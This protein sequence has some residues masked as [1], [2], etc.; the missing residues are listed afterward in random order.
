[1]SEIKKFDIDAP[2]EQQGYRYLGVFPRS[3]SSLPP[4]EQPEQQGYRYLGVF[5][6]SSSFLPPPPGKRRMRSPIAESSE[7]EGDPFAN[8]PFVF[9]EPTEDTKEIVEVIDTVV[10]TLTENLGNE[11]TSQII[12]TTPQA[13]KTL[14]QSDD[15][16]EKKEGL[17]RFAAY[18][19][20]MKD[21]KKK[22]LSNPISTGL[23]WFVWLWIMLQSGFIITAY[24]KEKDNQDPQYTRQISKGLYLF[25]VVS[26]TTGWVAFILRLLRHVPMSKEVKVALKKTEVGE[27]DVGEGETGETGETG[28]VDIPK[29]FHYETGETGEVVGMTGRTGETGGTETGGKKSLRSRAASG[30]RSGASRAKSA[31]AG[32][33]KGAAQFFKGIKAMD[34]SR[35]NVVK[36]SKRMSNVY[37]LILWNFVLGCWAVNDT[38]KSPNP[39]PNKTVLG[40][41]AAAIVVGVLALLVGILGAWLKKI[42]SS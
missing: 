7:R 41:G 11:T 4:P 1:M 30:F 37:L 32:V 2:P 26:M 33:K 10:D 21:A 28:E 38:R 39:G 27:I 24:R 17:A 14:L 16:N 3:S 36:T 13:I 34:A 40:L 6:P 23:W 18:L 9:D 35:E 15:L 22:I 8:F 20:L 42:Y 19:E 5:P 25:A 29:E 31:A 12:D